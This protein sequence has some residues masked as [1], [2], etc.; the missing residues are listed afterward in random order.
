VDDTPA[1][2]VAYES[3]LARLGQEVV[4]AR[5]GRE[6]LQ[7]FLQRDF[8]VAILD[9]NMPEMDGFET[10]GLIRQQPRAV[11]TPIIFVT[12]TGTSERQ[13]RQAYQI[14]AVDYLITPV[15]PEILRSKVGA[16]VEL[17]RKNSDLRNESREIEQ[18]LKES[19]AELEAFAYSVS[20]DLRAPLRGLQGFA[21]ALL[22]DCG[23]EL[24]DTSREYARRIAGA[25]ARMDHLIQDLL[26]YSR[27]SHGKLD[28]HPLD[29]GGVVYE[30]LAQ[31]EAPLRDSHA[32]VSTAEPLLGVVAHHCTLV[33]VIS[34]LLSNACK[35]V[36]PGVQPCI[37]IWME[38]R[39]NW[40][41]LWIQDNGIG[42][43]PEF[44]TRIFRVF[45][46]LHGVE[47]Y[48]GTGVGLAIV[49][50]GI[51][52]MGGRVGVESKPGEGSC[53]WLELPLA[54]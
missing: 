40:A 24:S 2:L 15:E 30:A 36:A 47:A 39:A 11:W 19:N 10:A 50:K 32:A 45:E 8:A 1:N 37:R 42:I 21:Q 34:N 17:N 26:L 49:R 12:A 35:F 44:H 38:Q 48:P 31:L 51:E 16:F 22:D 5:S 43:G 20:H 28:L 3:I 13:V 25:A 23:Q 9:V 6:A 18:V 46:R 52:R 33:Q 54:R 41:R 29:V 27:I 7:W 4:V 14:G 53:F